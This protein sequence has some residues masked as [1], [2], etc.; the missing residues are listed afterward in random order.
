VSVS[1]GGC[2]LDS[3]PFALYAKAGRGNSGK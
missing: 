1:R 3:F 2:V